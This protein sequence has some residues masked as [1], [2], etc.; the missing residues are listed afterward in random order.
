MDGFKCETFLENFSD[1]STTGLDDRFS[2]NVSPL[3]CEHLNDDWTM[4]FRVKEEEDE[5]LEDNKILPE[6]YSEHVTHEDSR[7]FLCSICKKNIVRL[8]STLTTRRKRR[9]VDEG[10]VLSSMTICQECIELDNEQL[11]D[12]KYAS[13]KSKRAVRRQHAKKRVAES[14]A[15]RKLKARQEEIMEVSK[16]LPENERKKLQQMIRNRISAQQSRDRKKAHL[17]QVE[18]EIQALKLENASLKTKLNRVNTENK[19]L[20]NQLS[21]LYSSDDSNLPNGLKQSILGISAVMCVV[22]LTQLIP[23]TSIPTTRMLTELP[24]SS[25]TTYN[26][27]AIPSESI[28]ISEIPEPLDT[29]YEISPIIKQLPDISR[30]TILDIRTKRLESLQSSS[31]LRSPAL[32]STDPCSRQLL[33]GV[34]DSKT[35]TTLYCPEVQSHWGESIGGDLQFIQMLVP[36]EALPSLTP[37]EDSRKYLVELMCKVGEVT[38]VS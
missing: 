35:L 38:L 21:R 29:F 19:Y 25:P 30:D 5:H 15:L 14:E 6:L 13:E 37:A 36:L 1:C 28:E 34:K 12:M 9:R 23:S 7:T 10:P 18:A 24:T 32:G 33:K 4:P 27:L 31:N 8:S 17:M 11:R 20:K 16:D 22:M 3:E 26:Q 2:S